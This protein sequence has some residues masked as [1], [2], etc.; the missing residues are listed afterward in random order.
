MTTADRTV[1]QE[2]RRN[3]SARKMAQRLGWLSIGLGVAEL[4]MPGPLSRTLGIPAAKGLVRLCGIR[5]VVTGVGLLTT[6]QPKPWM[7]AR[8]G[9]DALDLACLG[10]A[11]L[12]GNKPGHA[13]LAAGAV[14]GVTSLDLSCEQGLRKEDRPVPVY[15]Y[16]DR[17]GFPQT[18][19]KM[20]G[21]AKESSRIT[22]KTTQVT[23]MEAAKRETDSP[24]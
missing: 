4:L 5:E 9:G 10:S 7:M 16:S 15:D 12:I 24:V 11:A 3:Y 14:A 17:S 22:D 2:Y 13:M 19:D 1:K 8:V 18:P 6:D 20:R 21:K 23:G